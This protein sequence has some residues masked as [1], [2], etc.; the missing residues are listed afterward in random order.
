M[1]EITPNTDVKKEQE[2]AD[3]NN[4][5]AALLKE[6]ERELDQASKR[7]SFPMPGQG[8]KSDVLFNAIG[9]FA[10][11]GINDTTVQDLLEAANI[12][13]RTFYK[14]FKNKVDVLESIYQ[15]AAELLTTRFKEE[16]ANANSLVE[17][18][19]SCVDL[20]FDYHASLGP[21]VRMMT[22]EARRTGSPLAR[23][24]EALIKQVVGLFDDKYFEVNG[25]HLD[26][27]VH[28]SLIW[29]MESTSINLLTSTDCKQEDVDRYK[30]VMRAI[31]ARVVAAGDSDLPEL[32]S[33]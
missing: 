30:S 29:S 19:M 31:A 24:R 14:Y 10:K 2:S 1:E 22:E 9:V 3:D 15:L 5:I 13:R 27:L 11:K 7:P 28:Y 20:Y 33:M 32:P 25:R 16:R 4:F 18:V 6:T 17:F 12:S 23:H 26:P 21:L 8:A